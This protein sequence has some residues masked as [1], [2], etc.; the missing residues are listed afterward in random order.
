MNN[1]KSSK[2]LDKCQI[3]KSRNLKSI[4][5]LGSLP[6]VN[7]MQSINK[8]N[9]EQI[10]Y[11]TELFYSP[12]SHL[13][14]LGTIVDKEILFPPEYPYTSS[15]TKILRENFK[16][17]YEEIRKKFNFQKK[18]LVIDIGSNDGN[19]LFNFK[20]YFNVLGVTPETIGKLA[21]QKGIPTILDYYN[22]KTTKLILKKF[23]KANIITATNVF[24]HIDNIDDVII[25]IKKCLK[26]N[27]IFISES[28][29]LLPLIKKL[30]YDT[31]YH[32][33]LRYYSLHSLNYLFQKHKLE[34][35]HAKEIGTHGGSIRVYVSR[36]GLYKKS[37]NLKKQFNTEKKF[38]DFK[39]LQKFSNRVLS[40][41]IKLLKI[42][43]KLKLKKKSIAGISAPSRASTLINYVG[44]NQDLINCIF[45]IK[46]S[47]KIGYYAPGT[48]IP[49]LEEKASSLKKYDFLILFSWHIADDLIKNIKKKGFKGKFIIPLPEPK[50]I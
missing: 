21:I 30:Q 4:L 6:P 19:L 18:S 14:Q 38:I 35:F 20:K 33:H 45:E 1:M 37:K 2:T 5:N 26:K 39:S 43:N 7:K 46:N 8:K 23:G 15:T 12:K 27:G 16:E 22:S 24:A 50:I 36:K 47:H 17:L 42:L 11:P 29:Y 9:K 13:V 40:S 10:Y 41:K 44:I 32:E 34:I 28:H 49:I 48:N 3:S 25:N 31:V